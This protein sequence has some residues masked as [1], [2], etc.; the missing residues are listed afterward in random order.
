MNANE[1]GKLFEAPLID[2]EELVALIPSKYGLNGVDYV[3]NPI[4]VHKSLKLSSDLCNLEE[5]K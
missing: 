3:K 4:R 2:Y 5:L 1:E